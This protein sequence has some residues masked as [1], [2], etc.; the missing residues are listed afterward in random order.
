MNWKMLKLQ[1]RVVILSGFVTKI[2]LF[3]L[4]R[5]FTQVHD[6]LFI[7]KYWFVQ[8]SLKDLNPQL[9]QIV[10]IHIGIYSSPIFRRLYL[11]GKGGVVAKHFDTLPLF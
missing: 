10:R 11:R 7:K 8:L 3:T 9:L 1:S 5:P 6:P 2:L 4:L